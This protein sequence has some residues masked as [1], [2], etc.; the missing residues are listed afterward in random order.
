MILNI[1]EYTGGDFVKQ[2]IIDYATSVIWIKRFQAAGKFEL[3]IR[4]TRELFELFTRENIFITRDDSDG[5]M[6]VDKIEL[7]TDA[8]NG[9][10]LIISG[11]SA[12][13]LIG[14]RIIPVQ[15]NLSGTAENAIYTLLD[16]NAIIP[17]DTARALGPFVIGQTHEWAETIDQQITGKNLLDAIA[18]ICVTYNYGFK[19]DFSLG[20]FEFTLY[21]GTDRSFDQSENTFVIFAPEFENLGN[22]DYSRDVSTYFNDVYVA[23]EGEGSER[24]IVNVRTNGKSGLNLREKWIDARIIS[25][26]TEGGTLNPTQYNAVL[27]QKGNEE[28]EILRE[29]TKFSGEIL[30]HN[31]YTYG[32][33]YNLG[34]KIAVK[35][36]Y[37]ITGTAVISEITEVEDATGYSVYP[38]LSEWSV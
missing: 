1:W 38:T 33:D 9:D 7:K 28:I 29:T 30:P 8:L 4:A 13:S 2:K 32:V 26:K 36:E 12:E 22:T 21:K 34:D 10:Y 27:R 17:T 20:V 18:D 25:R 14:R 24:V 37:G 23:G 19:V 16:D 31:D 11:K 5:A 3:Y 6:C 35:N 15:T